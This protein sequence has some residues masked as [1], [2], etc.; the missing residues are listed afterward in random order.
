MDAVDLLDRGHGDVVGRKAQVAGQVGNPAL[1]RS[2]H[3]LTLRFA[4][5]LA[6]R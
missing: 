3:L 5:R 2:T 6:T 4:S 1:T